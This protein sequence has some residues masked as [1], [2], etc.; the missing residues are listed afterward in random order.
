M[1]TSETTAPT[2]AIDALG[3][4][5]K[6]H[7]INSWEDFERVYDQWFRRKRGRWYFRGQRD[8]CWPLR[9]TLERLLD[10]IRGRVVNA[11]PYPRYASGSVAS[12]VG[13]RIELLILRAFQARA[14]KFISNLPQAD[15][16]LEWL[17]LMRHWGLPARLLDVSTSP[18]VAL[19][20]ALC[21]L[22]QCN[23]TPDTLAAVWAI[24]HV[25]LRATGS[26]QADVF[27][28]TDLSGPDLFNEHFVGEDRKAFAAPVHPRTHNERLAA[29]QG[30]FLC[31]ADVDLSFGDNVTKHM[32]V[33]EL[34]GMSLVHRLEIARGAATE[35]LERLSSMNIH[36]ASLFPDLQ[37]Y[38]RFIE[39]CLLLFG[40]GD[41]QQEPHLDFESF[42]RL[43]W[44]G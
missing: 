11:E 18:Y 4:A 41:R 38:T 6:V 14:S 3:Q 29:Q 32:P 23:K 26:L 5:A 2:P 17:A 39:Q 40:A 24:N 1:S 36:S 35:F 21:D 10:P 30:T 9:T 27:A 34:S 37:G 28:H 33:N 8:A 25:P 43:G 22:L 19:Y 7:Q 13:A 42:E 44:L 12:S 31:I 20:F 15:E 16:T